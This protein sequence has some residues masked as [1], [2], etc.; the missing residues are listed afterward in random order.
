MAMCDTFVLRDFYKRLYR[1]YSCAHRIH[2][3]LF[4]VSTAALPSAHR[5][6]GGS[7]GCGWESEAVDGLW[8]WMGS[9]D[10]FDGGSVGCGWECLA[11]NTERN[12][13]I[14]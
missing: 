3:V 12:W 4:F 13:S 14:F 10:L 9:E 11:P 7:V 2:A 1:T 6:D 8:L 5:F